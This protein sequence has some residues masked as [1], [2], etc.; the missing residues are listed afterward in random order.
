MALKCKIKAKDE[1]LPVKGSVTEDGNGVSKGTCPECLT[2]DRKLTGKG[3]LGAHNVVLDVDTTIPVTD[4]GMRIGAPRDS[5]VKR[6]IEGRRISAGLAAVP[7]AART[8]A[9]QAHRG[10]TLV[11]GRD[12]VPRLREDGLSWDEGTDLRQ[13]GTVRKT[14]TLDAPLGRERF[15]RKITFVP[16]PAPVL[17]RSQKRARRRKACRTAHTARLTGSGSEALA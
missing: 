9:A 16:E 15:D 4:E 12:T 10:P 6:E 8:D 7:H 17:S 14:S 11:K 3:F 2:P 5:A 13:D 1:M